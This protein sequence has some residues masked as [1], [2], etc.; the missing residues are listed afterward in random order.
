MVVFLLVI[1]IV[2]GAYVGI[3]AYRPAIDEHKGKKP[4]TSPT[5][6][7]SPTPTI[8]P[9]PTPTPAPT[10]I[11]TPENITLSFH[12]EYEFNWTY[13]HADYGTIITLEV[14]S[15]PSSNITFSNNDI[16]YKLFPSTTYATY[17]GNF[18][19]QLLASMPTNPI[20]PIQTYTF[21]GVGH[22]GIF[23][24]QET[25]SPWIIDAQVSIEIITNNAQGSS[26]FMNLN[27]NSGSLGPQPSNLP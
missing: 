9:T 15:T 22:F 18:A 12:T 19:P 27:Q 16:T 11:P 1:L 13:N 5:P 10:P 26:F 2:A 17:S 8:S 3:N 6:T 24:P 14:D 21:D 4:A 25:G 23:F 20:N 7:P